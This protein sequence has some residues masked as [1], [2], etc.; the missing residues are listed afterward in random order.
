MAQ[1]LERRART[2]CQRCGWEDLLDKARELYWRHDG[3]WCRETVKA[4]GIT[5]KRMGHCTEKQRASIGRMWEAT[6][7]PPRR[8]KENDDGKRN[9]DARE[10]R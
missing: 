6:L 4:I 10:Q 9:K 3:A 8:R 1:V 2:L 5:I 7:N